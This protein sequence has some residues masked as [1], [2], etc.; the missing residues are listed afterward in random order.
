MRQRRAA[1]I[2]HFATVEEA[3][4]AEPIQTH[5]MSSYT[6]RQQIQFGST[7][8]KAQE[9]ETKLEEKYGDYDSYDVAIKPAIQRIVEKL[10]SWLE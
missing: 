8:N 5:K 9:I 3:E 4:V 6:V 10:C 2:P 7:H 1:K